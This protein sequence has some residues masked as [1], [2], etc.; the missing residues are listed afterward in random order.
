[1]VALLACETENHTFIL[2]TETMEIHDIAM[3]KMETTH[4]LTVELK[5][6]IDSLKNS[7]TPDSLK[8]AQFESFIQDLELADD[9]MMEWMG[10][11]EIELKDVDTD[12]SRIYFEEEKKKVTQVNNFYDDVIMKVSAEL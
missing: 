1:M 5:E 2:Y 10:N 7:A 6:R 8:I 3:A 12:E 9:G 4:K 11:F